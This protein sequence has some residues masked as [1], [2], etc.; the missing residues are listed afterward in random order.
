M[1]DVLGALKVSHQELYEDGL[2][3]SFLQNAR[4]ILC[5]GLV[6]A[7][8]LS[9]VATLT[10]NDST[11][12]YGSLIELVLK[13]ESIDNTHVDFLTERLNS[14]LKLKAGWNLEDSN[15]IDSKVV[16]FVKKALIE[17]DASAWQRW[18]AFPEKRGSVLLDYEDDICQA[19]ISIGTDGFSYMAY[20]PGFYD[21]AERS[22]LSES[23]LLA[24]VRKVKQYRH[25]Y[26]QNT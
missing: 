16:A 6:A 4:R 9:S 26:S 17:S 24:F 15:P 19:C 23:E 20:G 22:G 13:T 11:T 7:T 21:T 1:E 12:S 10:I 5:S 3:E 18:L 25:G 2:L 8:L 14:F